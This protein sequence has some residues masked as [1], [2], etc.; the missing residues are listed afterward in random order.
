MVHFSTRYWSYSSLIFEVSNHSMAFLIKFVTSLI[1]LTSG[2]IV[3]YDLTAILISNF[4]WPTWGGATGLGAW[5]GITVTVL[6]WRWAGGVGGGWLERRLVRNCDWTRE[7]K[8]S[9]SIDSASA[10]FRAL[11]S[12]SVWANKT[13]NWGLMN[14]N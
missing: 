12:A 10:T 5:A 2:L 3:H 4:F 8:F 6:V 11:I 1:C 9:T 14:K 7:Y 13:T